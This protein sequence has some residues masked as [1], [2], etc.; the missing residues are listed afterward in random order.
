MSAHSSQRRK[1]KIAKADPIKKT[2]KSDIIS[3]PVTVANSHSQRRNKD[4]KAVVD[5]SDSPLKTSKRQK[6]I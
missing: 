6:E 1:E 2:T 3:G 5:V 4:F